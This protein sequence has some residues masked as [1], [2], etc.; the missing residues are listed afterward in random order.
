M[1]NPSTTY[2]RVQARD[3]VGLTSAWVTL[4]TLKYDASAPTNPTPFSSS[5]TSLVWSNDPTVDM[6]WTGAADGAGSGVSGYSIEWSTGAT[7]IPDTTQDTTGTSL[8]STAL[9]EGNSWYFHI[10]ARDAAGNWASGAAH[11]GPFYIDVTPPTNAAS[12]VETHGAVSG[13]WQSAVTDPAFTW[14]AASD[15]RSGLAGYTVYWGLDSGGTSGTWSATAAYDPPALSSQGAY[16]LRVQSQDAA[17][18]TSAWATLFTL[19]YDVVAPTNPTVNSPD[20]TAGV[21]SND[22]VV[23]VTWF[24]A[25]DG[26]GSGIQGYSIEWSTS[27]VTLPDATVDTTATAA[28]SAP[29]ADGESWYFHIRTRDV[30]GNWNSAAAHF[31]PIMIDTVAPTAPTSAVELGA[32]PQDTW[33]RTNDDANFTWSGAADD[34]SGVAGYHVY[35]GASPAGTSTSFV[36]SADYDP[37]ALTTTVIYYL[38]LQT[39]DQAGNTSGWVTLFTLRYD[40]EA[41]G[42]AVTFISIITVGQS[43]Q[44]NWS[45]TDGGSGL[46]AYDVQYRQGAGGTWTDWLTATTQTSAVFG[47]TSPVTPILG[48]TYTFRTRAVDRVGNLELYPPDGDRSLFIQDS[49]AFFLPVIMHLPSST[50]PG[51]LLNGNFE[52]GPDVGWQEISQHGWNVVLPQSGLPFLVHG[53][54][55][56]AWLG[57]GDDEITTL[58]QQVT[59]SASSP[60][61]RFWYWID[62]ADSCGFDFGKIYLGAT[63]V[64]SMNLCTSTNTGS[65][66]ARSV[67]LLA[68]AGQTL[69]LKFYLV[70]DVIYFSSWFLDDISFGSAPLAPGQ[71]A[72]LLRVP[73]ISRAEFLTR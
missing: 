33:Q 68:Y 16:Y 59:I 31:G 71:P 51:A 47:P 55:Y 35:W 25:G 54:T 49:Y 2:L 24:G 69:V 17:G 50:P 7:T 60:I 67:D 18:N 52:Q 11:L 56:A 13:V 29:L 72:T 44:V 26:T 61:L 66:V 22:N 36:S 58:T 73:S 65:R 14:T 39:K 27:A 37:P 5:H 1:A 43:Y 32:I 8:T 15:S 46:A 70:T 23:D 57:G 45:G 28:A 6:A 48:E 20:H 63:Q 42:S 3:N 30:A 4:F 19:M 12:A 62:S 41:P 53:G 34:R 64:D 38:R 10:R 21:W 9:A 40:P